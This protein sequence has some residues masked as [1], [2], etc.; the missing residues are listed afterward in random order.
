[1]KTLTPLKNYNNQ[2]NYHSEL[3]EFNE[4]NWTE[5][6]VEIDDID[7]DCSELTKD[8]VI[9]VQKYC[10]EI[11]QDMKDL[12]DYCHNIAVTENSL[13]YLN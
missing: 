9:F 7:F 4:E 13:R 11:Q 3:I 6:Y 8:Q 12:R 5:I 2:D 1:M 10:E